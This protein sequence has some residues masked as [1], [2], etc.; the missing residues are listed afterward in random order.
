VIAPATLRLRPGHSTDG[1]E[2][3]GVLVAAWRGGY[4][5]IVPDDVIEAQTVARWEPALTDAVRNSETRTVVAVDGA[6]AVVGFAGFGADPDDP[7]PRAGFLS[8]LYVDPAASGAGLGGR[9]VAQTLSELADAGC[10]T[11]RLWVFRDNARARALYERCGF[12]ADGAE[13]VD[14]R[15]R[16][17]QVRYR[18]TLPDPV[19]AEKRSQP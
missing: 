9:L 1:A 2:M 3:A 18:R 4:R 13:F 16:A 8:S 17:P 6:G 14:P 5:G 15:W 10:T 12:V 11:V 7:D 19:A